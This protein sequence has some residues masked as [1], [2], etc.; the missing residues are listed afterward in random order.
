MRTRK[1]HSI[2]HDFT[3]YDA[4]RR[5]VQV[6]P[7][8]LAFV[9]GDKRL[10]FKQFF[11]LVNHLAVGIRK[12][13]IKRGDRIGI[14]SRNNLEY[15]ALYFAA[16]RCGAI[17]VPVNTRLS[18][19]EIQYI[20]SDCQPKLLFAD[21][22]F[23]P[24]LDPDILKI[25][26]VRKRF[27][28]EEGKDHFLD[29]DQLIHGD[30]D[31]KEVHIRG[32]DGLIIIYTA[33]VEGR[34]RGAMLSHAN[35]LASNIQI[36]TGLSLKSDDV[37]LGVLPLFHVA[38]LIFSSNIFHTGAANVILSQFDPLAALQLIQRENISILFEFSPMLQQIVEKMREQK[39]DASSVR[40]VLG[41]TYPDCFEEFQAETKAVF[42][43]VWGQTET[44][45][46][47]TA[48]RHDE[49]PG[50]VGRALPLT[51]IRIVDDQG[52]P[53]GVG[54]P[55]EIV[56]RSP[57]VFKGY[58]NL[59][60]ETTYTF[61]E[62]WHHTGD[63]GRLDEEGFLSFVGRKQEKELIK[64]G[65]ENVYPA[66]V[67]SAILKHPDIAEVSVIGVSDPKWV[68]SIKAVCVTKEG[69]VVTEKELIDF[70]SQRIAPYKKPR[71]VQFVDGLPKTERG[72]IDRAKVKVKYGGVTRQP[73]I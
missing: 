40:L 48:C 51:H 13:G 62:G 20:L 42:Y 50:S 18:Q 14:M 71:I 11:D 38:G 19:E 68:E 45:S 15:V 65:G 61:R 67:E 63:L 59:E 43:R 6:F 10:T 60:E 37:Y 44:S 41:I 4:V 34:P 70:V 56:V 58:W 33:A 12:E 25:D 22:F 1:G 9:D 69:R 2:R 46:F 29:F 64:T 36:M 32:E 26:S 49:R 30:T 72:E 5:N 66:E 27:S 53:A 21:S 8:R 7:D 28:M 31:M 47:I 52:R 35:V 73:P 57:Q 16:A 23:H 3:L 24:M 55:G 39:Y 17:F 54:Q